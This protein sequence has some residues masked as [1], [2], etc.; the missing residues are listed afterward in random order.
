M[1]AVVDMDQNVYRAG[2]ND[3]TLSSAAYA[4]LN[5][6]SRQNLSMSADRNVALSSGAMGR[7]LLLKEISL[8]SGAH[9]ISRRLQETVVKSLSIGLDQGVSFAHGL[10]GVLWGV[11]KI[12]HSSQPPEELLEAVHSLDKKLSRRVDDLAHMRYE[13]LYGVAG[14]GKYAI[15]RRSVPVHEPLVEA[16][17]S[18]LV[19]QVARHDGCV[20]TP[21]NQILNTGL[22]A[23]RVE[24][25]IDLGIAHGNAGLL[26]VLS[27]ALNRGLL[28]KKACHSVSRLA[29]D[30]LT[31]VRIEPDGNQ[32]VPSFAHSTVRCHLG[33]C[34]GTLST[35]VA[36]LNAAVALKHSG[37]LE[38]ARR[39]ALSAASTSFAD[40]HIR[41]LTFCHGKMGVALIFDRLARRLEQDSLYLA[42]DRWLA[43]ALDWSKS[44]SFEDY[45]EPLAKGGGILSGL[46][47]VGL[48]LLSI[49]KGRALDWEGAV[50][51]DYDHE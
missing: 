39:L 16:V 44:K 33:W 30:L 51:L 50:L 5:F 19:E 43:S 23:S 10:S 15:D 18:V 22:R 37:L 14:I 7:F 45:W 34:Y 20:I 40:S 3:E 49:L 42:R 25:V 2:I 38:S 36:I 8:L 46:S 28:P 48:S 21:R 41:E 24:G 13:F 1:G 27:Q 12:V 26:S 29:H 47:G 35:A 31:Y 17:F 32:G 9:E 6:L 11:D 4:S